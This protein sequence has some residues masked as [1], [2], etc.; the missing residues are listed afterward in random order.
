MRVSKKIQKMDFNWL[1]V[2]QKY[3]KTNSQSFYPNQSKGK[4]SKIL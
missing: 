3:K 2:C 1:R 4:N